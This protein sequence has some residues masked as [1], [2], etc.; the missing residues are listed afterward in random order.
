MIS[1]VLMIMGTI[2]LGIVI[3]AIIGVFLPDSIGETYDLQESL[4]GDNFIST[5]LVV[6][7]APAVC[8]EMMFRGYV[9]SAFE[10]K[11][12]PKTAMLISACLFGIYH[13]SFVRFIVTAFIGYVTCYVVYKSKSLFVGMVMHFIN[14]GLSCV[15]MYYPKQ[16]G[17]IFPILTSETLNLFDLFFLILIGTLLVY[18]GYILINTKKEKIS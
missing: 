15:I 1:G 13:M 6:A 16:V 10:D 8:E 7:V 11:L 12:K 2:L 5:L 14:N 4:M 17:K 18:L 9:F 3:T